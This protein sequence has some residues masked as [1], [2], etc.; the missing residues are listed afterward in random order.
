MC[1]DLFQLAPIESS[2][3]ADVH[4]DL[5]PYPSSAS[6]ALHCPRSGRAR[7]LHLNRG[8]AFQA[9]SWRAAGL[10]FVEL[11]KVYRQA[12]REF[13]AALMRVREAKTTAEDWALFD[14]RVS[15]GTT[16]RSARAAA[17]PSTRGGVRAPAAPVA[18]AIQLRPTNA[19]P[20][21]SFLS[22]CAYR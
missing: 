1:G 5:V 14:T 22:F 2:L 15:G 8:W 10:H 16:F 13:I 21:L 17:P 20:F 12:D 9:D 4:A 3:L 6:G 18:R 7:E 11:T 19:G